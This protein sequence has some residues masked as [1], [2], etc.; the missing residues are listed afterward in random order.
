MDYAK[1]LDCVHLDYK[2]LN[3]LKKK[4]I[5]K[6]SDWGLSIRGCSGVTKTNQIGG[7]TPPYDDPELT[8]KKTLEYDASSRVS[9]YACD[10]YA[11]GIS[12]LHMLGIPI[13]VLESVKTTIGVKDKYNL[14]MSSQIEEAIANSKTT[15][16]SE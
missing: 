4:Y 5:F 9:H 7:F 16:A 14:N 10:I 15:K 2:P 13:N 3:I 1:N 11:L 12:L 8:N 6:I